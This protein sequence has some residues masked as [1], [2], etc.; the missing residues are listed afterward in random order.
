[1]I[2]QPPRAFKGVLE[3]GQPAAAMVLPPE[4]IPIEGAHRAAAPAAVRD[5]GV[6][7]RPCSPTGDGSRAAS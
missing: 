7:S 1:V 3:R 4:E 6:G 5:G 2:L